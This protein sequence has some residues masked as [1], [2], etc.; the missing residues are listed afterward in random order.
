MYCGKCGTQIETNALFCPN[1]GERTANIDTSIN[2][3]ASVKIKKIALPL[4][5]VAGVIAV[6][7]LIISLISS[8]GY[9]KRN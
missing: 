8:G 1:C 3:Q 6:I 9:K 7:V 5:V 4:V 2:K